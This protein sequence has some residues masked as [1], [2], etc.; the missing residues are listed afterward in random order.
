MDTIDAVIVIA[1]YGHGRRA[2]VLS[3]Y[4]FAVRDENNDN[5][6]RIIGKAYSGLTD[7]EID[8]ITKHLRSIMI[9]DN[10]YGIVVKPEL[11]LE[12]SFDSIQKSDRHDSGFALRF[13]RIKNIRSDK[14]IKDIDTLQKVRRIYENQTYP[15]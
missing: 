2:G 1:E 13:P 5:Q 10:G 14:N 4:T 6:L 12:I 15:S 9:K 7:K 3:D 11:I 8:T